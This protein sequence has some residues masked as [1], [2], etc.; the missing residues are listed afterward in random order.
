[1][2]VAE[3]KLKLIREIDRL[4]PERLNELE[5]FVQK[6]LNIPISPQTREIGSL[7]GGL[8]YMAPDFDAPLDD[9]KDYMWCH[10]S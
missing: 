6:L 2:S 4:P 10:I 5:H 1:M 9:F 3:L 7:K 8:L